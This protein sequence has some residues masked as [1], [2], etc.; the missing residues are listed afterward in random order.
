VEE[1]LVKL[2]NW[3]GGKK[4]G[5]NP[6]VGSIKV[7]KLNPQ[8]RVPSKAHDTD[9]GF[10]LYSNKYELILAGET[11]L[12]GTG[13][14]M[15]IPRE[16]SGFIWDRS[17]MGVKG[18]HRFA[19]V[20][21]SDYRGEIKVCIHNASGEDYTIREGDKVAQLVIQK[22][23]YFFLKEVDSLEDTERGNKGFGSSG[24]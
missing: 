3:L 4:M 7:Q 15:S 11:K 12:I 23:P 17:S 16:Y 14:A 18:L 19:G 24:I 6:E 9:A 5:G 13:I 22:V 20:I 21:D 10:D 8:A 1:A 2:F